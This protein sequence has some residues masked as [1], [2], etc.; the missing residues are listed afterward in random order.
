MTQTL[1]G[2][3]YPRAILEQ[4]SDLPGLD[5]FA[6]QEQLPRRTRRAIPSRCLVLTLWFAPRPNGRLLPMRQGTPLAQSMTA[7]VRRARMVP[8]STL[9]N[10][11]RCPLQRVTLMD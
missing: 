7:Q 4:R 8:P 5:S 11:V 3:F 9:N 6:T 1:I 10:A 2:R